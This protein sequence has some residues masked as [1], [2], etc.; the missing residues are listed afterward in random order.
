MA[1]A[2]ITIQLQRSFVSSYLSL[3][4]QLGLSPNSLLLLLLIRFSAATI[5]HRGSFDTREGD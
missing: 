3:K 4:R 1:C 5:P 2:R